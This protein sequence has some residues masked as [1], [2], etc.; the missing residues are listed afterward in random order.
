MKQVSF[1]NFFL[2]FSKFRN[3]D[4]HRNT[5]VI[6]NPYKYFISTTTANYIFCSITY[7]FISK[8][9]GLATPIKAKSLFT[10]KKHNMGSSIPCSINLKVKRRAKI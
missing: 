9:L 7:I 1:Y 3:S 6:N 5:C 8:I 10:N 4:L 2:A